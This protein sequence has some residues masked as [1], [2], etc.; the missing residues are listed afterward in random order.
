MYGNS[1][2]GG[3]PQV[4]YDI[5]SFLIYFAGANSAEPYRVKLPNQRWI[6]LAFNYHTEHADF[7]VNGELNHT[8]SFTD[9]IPPSG[10]SS[11]VVIIGQKADK[12][13]G[14]MGGIK[15]SI[16][17]VRYYENVLSLYDLSNL[18]NIGYQTIKAKDAIST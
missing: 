6:H 9:G 18:Y 11:D 1:D 15:G 7:F 12:K 5:D 4:M 10:T 2:T 8:Y 3:K 16:R 14:I 17:D 13:R